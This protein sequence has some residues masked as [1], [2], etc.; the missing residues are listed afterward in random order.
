MDWPVIVIVVKD[1]LVDLSTFERKCSWRA[2]R[3]F[4]LWC[5]LVQAGAVVEP[6]SFC[7][8]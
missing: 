1:L 2:L 6:R 3:N 4:H 8:L 5:H 7:C